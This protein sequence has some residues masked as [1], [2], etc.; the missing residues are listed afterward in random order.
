MTLRW[1]G[2]R[3]A[4]H[5]N[6]GLVMFV[7]PQTRLRRDTTVQVLADVMGMTLPDLQSP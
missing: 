4:G 5:P 3:G 6:D 2:R 7:I 1:S